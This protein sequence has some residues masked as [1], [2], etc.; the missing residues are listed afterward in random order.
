MLGRVNHHV[1][2]RE[3]T[4]APRA[5]TGRKQAPSVIR[6]PGTT[7]SSCAGRPLVR[8]LRT[9]LTGCRPAVFGGTPTSLRRTRWCP[10]RGR[11]TCQSVSC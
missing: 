9:P 2:T 6:A 11:S 5:G 7:S 3:K 4:N 10:R 8:G 1:R